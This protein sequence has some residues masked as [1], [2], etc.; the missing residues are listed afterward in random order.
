MTLRIWEGFGLGFGHRWDC[1]QPGF[2][3]GCRGKFGLDWM[4]MY[5]VPGCGDQ[6]VPWA[7]LV[8]TLCLG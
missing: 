6:L 1:G 8:L 5:I 7:A 4:E 3:R 2:T